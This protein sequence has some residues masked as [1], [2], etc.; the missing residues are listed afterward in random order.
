MVREL[1]ACLRRSGAWRLRVGPRAWCERSQF[2]HLGSGACGA[3]WGLQDERM[4]AKLR[5]CVDTLVY[6]TS[7]RVR[8]CRACWPGVLWRW[9]VL[10]VFVETPPLPGAASVLVDWPRA[11]G[12][13]LQLPSP[14]GRLER[15][16]LSPSACVLLFVT[17]ASSRV[18]LSRA[19]RCCG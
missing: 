14:R 9:C 13:A 19:A 10:H 7:P 16:V 15:Y 1:V 6:G 8:E 2:F 4:V 5:A 3:E 17:L 18:R 11:L 12:G